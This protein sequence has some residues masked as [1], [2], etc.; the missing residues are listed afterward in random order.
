MKQ[1]FEDFIKHTEE[2]IQ[3]EQKK[4]SIEM[5]Q[6]LLN[7]GNIFHCELKHF[8][9]VLKGDYDLRKKDM[10][11]NL[12]R[13][14]DFHAPSL[15]TN[16]LEESPRLVNEVKH[17]LLEKISNYTFQKEHY[18]EIMNQYVLTKKERLEFLFKNN[19]K[20]FIDLTEEEFL[21]LD[22]RIRSFLQAYVSYALMEE[23][24]AFS[25]YQAAFRITKHKAYRIKEPFMPEI[26]HYSTLQ[27]RIQDKEK[28]NKI[29]KQYREYVEL[30]VEQEKIESI[31]YKRVEKEH[32]LSVIYY[33]YISEKQ[34]ELKN[35]I[36]QSLEK[37]MKDM[38]Q[39]IQEILDKN[40][41]NLFDRH[42]KEIEDGIRRLKE[43]DGYI[44]YVEEE[45]DN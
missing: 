30:H 12:D 35:K 37:K 1:T 26:P 18:Y 40:Q 15:L 23:E 4:Q 41:N 8:E 10:K 32:Y 29:I 33:V 13:I 24:D 9:Q 28:R 36:K 20:P 2:I 19:G 17:I 22:E 42:I 7:N 27:N 34:T 45:Y 11:K 21:D 38:Q 43:W 39:N 6:R 25:L 31:F 3:K 16:I 44:Q 14:Y 5:L